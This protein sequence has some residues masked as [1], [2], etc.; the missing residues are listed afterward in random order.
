MRL[1][2]LILKEIKSTKSRWAFAKGEKQRGR[3]FKKE[4]RRKN[5]RRPKKEKRRG[6]RG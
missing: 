4:S 2:T 6:R 5:K 1:N 3:I